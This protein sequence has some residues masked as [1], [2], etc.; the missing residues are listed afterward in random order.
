MD[1]TRH[2]R[3]MWRFYAIDAVLY[4]VCGVVTGG[5]LRSWVFWIAGG[6]FMVLAWA[7]WR[8]LRRTIVDH[9]T[10]KLEGDASVATTTTFI[11]RIGRAKMRKGMTV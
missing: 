4:T 1:E 9:V 2:D 8:R 3:F 7:H 11:E 10:H 6:A 5:D